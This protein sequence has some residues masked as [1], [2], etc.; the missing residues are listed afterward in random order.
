[1]ELTYTFTILLVLSS[2]AYTHGKC[3]FDGTIHEKDEIFEHPQD[4]CK[5]CHCCENGS[6]HCVTCLYKECPKPNCGVSMQQNTT[7]GCCLECK[8]ECNS[9]SC[10]TS[11]LDCPESR[12]AYQHDSCC[13]TCG[14][15][16]RDTIWRMDTVP[17]GPFGSCDRCTCHQNGTYT[18]EDANCPGQKLECVN[19]RAKEN[20]SNCDFE[21]PDG[22]TCRR[23][24]VLLKQNEWTKISF[25]YCTCFQ[26]QWYPRGACFDPRWRGELIDDA[27]A[28]KCM[29]D[30]SYD[31][32]TLVPKRR[33]DYSRYFAL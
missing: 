30:F 9:V 33:I 32:V 28:N 13:P 7:D 29:A 14:C 16:T 5:V 8:P 11:S 1:M 3:K 12:Y 17:Q 21:C 20:G 31:N 23:T 25:L 4:H 18:C 22:Y 6:F 24:N 26:D 15:N 2:I 27:I 10:S 19:P